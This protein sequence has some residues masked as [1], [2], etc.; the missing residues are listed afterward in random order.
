VIFVITRADSVGG[1]T[2]HVRDLARALLETGHWAKVLVGGEGPVTDAFREAGVPYR[3]LRH[4]AREINLRNDF[5]G[6]LELR[7]ALRDERPDLVS[8]HT[9]KA[10]FLGRLSAASLGIPA[11]YTPH[12]WSFADGF[13]GARRYLWA[14]RLARPFGRRTIAVSE[15]ERREGIARRVGP[16]DHFATVHNGMPDI[17]KDLRANPG[18]SPPRIVMVGRLEPQ[19]DHPALLQALAQLKNLPWTLDCIGDGP[20]R[21]RT[22][23]AIRELD[24][25]GRVNLLG[26]RRDVVDLLSRAQLFVLATNWESF[27][28]SILEA[29]RAG[30]PVVATAVGGTAEAVSDRHTGYLVPRGDANELAWRLCAL[31]ADP[32]LRVKFGAAARRR[33]EANF[34]H[35]RMVKSTLRVWETVLGRSLVSGGEQ[36]R[37]PDGSHRPAASPWARPTFVPSGHQTFGLAAEESPTP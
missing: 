16:P 33:Y 7:A 26:Y 11:I 12:C 14:E 24:L 19:K 6:L 30:L 18:I 10:G 22:E 3:S 32:V 15:A 21:S 37:S 25:G 34:T 5:A 28:R 35:D 36:S 31:V 2:I 17:P 4:L 8:T 13:P 20:L 23:T 9:S 29:M 1:A 27:P